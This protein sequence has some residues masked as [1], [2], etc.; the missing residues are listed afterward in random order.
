MKQTHHIRKSVLL[1]ASLLAMSL[2]A[3]TIDTSFIDDLMGDSSKPQTTEEL[4]EAQGSWSLI[5]EKQAP[6]PFQQHL[7]ARDQVDPTQLASASSYT[8]QYRTP[9]QNEQDVH[10]RLLRMERAVEGIRR[11]IN[12]LLPPLSNL[13]VSDLQLDRTIREIAAQPG[14]APRAPSPHTSSFAPHLPMQ[15]PPAPKQAFAPPVQATTHAMAKPA[16][17]PKAAAMHK[18]TSMPA[19]MSQKYSG[20]PAVTGVRTGKYPNRTRMVLDLNT[21]AKY[22]YDIDNN[23]RLMLVE[24]P[25]VAWNSAAQRRL[26][27]NPLVAGYTAQASGNGGT[28]LVIELKRQARVKEVMALPPNAKYGN[29]IFFDIVPL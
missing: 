26:T 24:L 5:E 28:M 6:S 16:A 11:D 8:P 29:R 17:M 4:L 9:T 23:E 19:S 27:G 22:S 20:A 18:K 13:I 3:C 2:S 25:G 10:Y 12:K 14:G 21:A 1:G 15:A 7:S